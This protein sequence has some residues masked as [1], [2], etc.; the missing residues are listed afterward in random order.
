MVRSLQPLGQLADMELVG[1]ICSLIISRKMTQWNLK[2][3]NVT[4]WVELNKM[5]LSVQ[6]HGGRHLKKY[7]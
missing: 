3:L 2:L 7:E 1:A 4:V 6:A 5:E